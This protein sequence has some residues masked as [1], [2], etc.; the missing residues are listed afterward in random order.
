MVLQGHTETVGNSD[1]LAR[2]TDTEDS[3]ES[4][5]MGLLTEHTEAEFQ[6]GSFGRDRK[7]EK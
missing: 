7:V 4:L 6:L 2:T 1:R 3:R 5:S